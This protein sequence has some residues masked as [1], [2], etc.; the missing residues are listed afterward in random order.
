MSFFSFFH[1]AVLL[2]GIKNRKTPVFN[3]YAALQN[4]PDCG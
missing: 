3:G 4:T 1:L 2:P